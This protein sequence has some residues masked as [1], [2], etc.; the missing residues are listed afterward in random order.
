MIIVWMSYT[1][2][3]RNP[4]GE[5]LE[6]ARMDGASL[7]DEILMCSHADGNPGIAST[8][9]LTSFWR[10]TRRSTPQPH[11]RE[12]TAFHRELFPAPRALRKFR[13]LLTMAIAPILILGH[14][15]RNNLYQK[16]AASA[17]CGMAVR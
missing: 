12:G 7:K 11:R 1:H 9:L 13:R 6:V 17:K 4:S 8:I 2:S 10:G 3:P 5:I 15:A 14:P 16:L